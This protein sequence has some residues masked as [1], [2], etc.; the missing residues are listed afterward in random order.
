[1]LTRKPFRQTE[2]EIKSLTLLQNNSFIQKEIQYPDP[3][4]IVSNLI[5]ETM[6][7]SGNS[8]IE[9]CPRIVTVLELSSGKNV[10]GE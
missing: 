9:A 2:I 7:F 6:M 1:M 10:I 5:Y 8:L 4:G 3:I